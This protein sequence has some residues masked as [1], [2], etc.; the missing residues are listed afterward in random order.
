MDNINTL[1]A[2][3]KVCL[4]Q[5]ESLRLWRLLTLIHITGY[6]GLSPTYSKENLFD[7]LSE[8]YGLLTPG[9][10][11]AIHLSQMDVDK[12]SDRGYKTCLVWA[13]EILHAGAHRGDISPPKHAYMSA[14]GA[15][16]ACCV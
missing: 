5:S 6:C 14:S 11:E 8:K 10:P 3:A 13:L 16:A 12:D 15:A 1:M 4:P 2:D 7:A 9:S